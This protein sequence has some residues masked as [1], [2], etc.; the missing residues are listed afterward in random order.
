MVSMIYFAVNL[1]ISFVARSLFIHYLGV[2]YNG[3]NSLFGSVISMLS[4]AELGFGNA[5]IFSMYKPLA[6]ENVEKIKSLMR[7][8]KH[9]YEIVAG[10]VF[11]LGMIIMPFIPTFVGKID[12]DVNLHWA[13]FLTLMGTVSSYLFTYNRSLV[14][15]DQ[16]NYIIT[17]CDIFYKIILFLVQTLILVKTRNFGLYLLMQII[18]TIL[19]NVVI[20]IIAKKKYPYLNEQSTK[21]NKTDVI[22]IMTKVKGLLFH[23]VASFV[24]LGTDSLLISKFCGVIDVGLYGN[25]TILINALNSVWTLVS[26]SISASIGNLLAT[27]DHKKSYAVYQKARFAQV[28]ITNFLA[29]TAFCLIQPFIKLWL[30]KQY[31]LSMTTVVVLILN[32]YLQVNRKMLNN[33]KETAGIYYEDRFVPV[34]EATVN[35]LLS[36][37]L[38]Y[39]LGIAGILLATISSTLFVVYGYGYP[40]YVYQV[41]FKQST[42]HYFKELTEDIF[43]F[44]VILLIT[45]SLVSLV[46]INNLFL[47]IAVKLLLCTGIVNGLLLM[48]FWRN[49][50]FT[51]WKKK[52]LAILQKN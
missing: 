5:I 11:I 19:E 31:L 25:Y 15:A 8:Y 27:S 17:W 26:S 41:I 14:I 37:V 10:V 1:I 51:Y 13:F 3:I 49:D 20:T 12:V 43:V 45:N 29:V 28:W 30:G 48:I 44:L 9:I 23:K 33:F 36:I 38:G 4:I 7:F 39:K 16:K 46:Q 6:D 24:V 52:A 22:S 40:K 32:F 2:E 47:Q 21:L 34:I 50:N 42:K 35:F 18:C